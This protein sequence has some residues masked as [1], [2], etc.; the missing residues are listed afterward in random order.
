[1]GILVEP[2]FSS[3]L[4]NFGISHIGTMA[5]GRH[6]PV[7][8][9]FLHFEVRNQSG[10]IANGYSE[11]QEHDPKRK[12]MRG[13]RSHGDVPL[14]KKRWTSLEEAASPADFGADVGADVF[15]GSLW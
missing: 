10:V 8:A 7:N 14:A 15:G 3:P 13:K 5:S 4:P 9:L 1:M 11:M 2:N 12:G 6:A